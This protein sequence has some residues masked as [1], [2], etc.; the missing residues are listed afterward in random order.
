VDKKWKFIHNGDGW[1]LRIESL[2]QLQ[3]YLEKTDSQKF[4]NN[5][6]RVAERVANGRT[7]KDDH[8]CYPM[9]DAIET[10]WKNSGKT[11]LETTGNLMASCH[12]TYVNR[13]TED[14]FVNIN[15]VGGCN[16][17][18][19]DVKAVEYRDELIFPCYTEKDIKIKTWELNEKKNGVKRPSGYKYHW[20]A[21]LGDV[22]LKDG[23]KEKWDT[24]EEAE[25]FAKSLF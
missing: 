5:M 15:I 10:L 11:L 17:F 8:G 12:N 13:I 23:D 7:E 16:S 19:W 2:E 9:A 1:W 18:D 25:A 14:G 24:R 22:Q 3:K 21:Y 20:Y 6:L 4:G